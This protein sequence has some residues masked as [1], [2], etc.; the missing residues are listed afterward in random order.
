MKITAPGGQG[1]ES[2]GQN[3]EPGKSFKIVVSMSTR[4]YT[5]TLNKQIKIQTNDPQA[6]L[7]ILTMEA[8][9]LEVL[10]VAPRLVNFGKVYRGSTHAQALTVKNK[11][12]DPVEISRI[13]ARPETMVAIS[14]TKPF[15]LKPGEERQF[16]LTFNTGTAKGHTGG[17]IS[18]FTN[19]EYLPEK[20]IRV[21]AQVVE[22]KKP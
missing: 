2:H 19:V 13:T 22:E 21:R 7:V 6:G 8:R 10:S 1:L 16:E 20:I 15:T 5:K 3:I 14:P 17:Y 12:K 11:G 4:G 18:L 9:I